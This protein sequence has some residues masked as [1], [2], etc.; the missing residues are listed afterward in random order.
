[1]VGADELLDDRVRESVEAAI[2]DAVRQL[3]LPSLPVEV[4]EV[5]P[6]RRGNGSTREHYI[7]DLASSLHRILARSANRELQLQATELFGVE[8]VSQLDSAI[9]ARL[10]ALLI[11][12]A[13]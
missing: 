13:E 3:N 1:M 7:A 8:S 2:K 4:E 10:T 5:K 9:Q 6:K 12:S 11:P